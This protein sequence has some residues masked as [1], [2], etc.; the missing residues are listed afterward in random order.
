[1][2]LV[3]HLRLTLPSSY[4]F[5]C[6]SLFRF[7]SFFIF[8]TCH[9]SI[10]Y[11]CW[12][13]S[14]SFPCFFFFSIVNSCYLLVISTTTQPTQS[15]LTAGV[16]ALDHDY[17]S[18]NSCVLHAPSGRLLL[19]STEHC[20]WGVLCLLTNLPARWLTQAP[21]QPARRTTYSTK[22]LLFVIF[23]RSAAFKCLEHSASKSS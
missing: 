23:S 6:S 16:L 2:T 18:Q 20:Q 4:C 13:F 7:F 1:M 5:C 8:L 19:T 9:L 14:D 17:R 15:F 10:S 12:C 11:C 22:V 21:S 3:A